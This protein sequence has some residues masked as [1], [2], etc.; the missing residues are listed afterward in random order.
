M[1]Q[2]NTGTS[3][4]TT[5]FALS[6]STIKFGSNIASAPD[7]IIYQL[8]AGIGTPSDDTVTSAKIVDGAIVNADI[9]ASAAIA[10]SKLATGA[11]PSGITVASANITDGTIVNADVNASAAIA[12]SKLATGLLPSG[13][14]INA[15]N[16]VDGTVVAAD[17]AANAITASELADDAVDTDAILNNAVTGAKIAMGSDAAGDI[18]YYNGTDY[19]R[20]P[21]GTA[22]QSLKVNSGASAPEW[23]TAAAGA[24]GGGT[25]N[26]FWENEATM[27]NSYTISTN[28]NA[29]VFGP[30]TVASGATITVPSG[31][32]LS[33]V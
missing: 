7:F 33:I 27:N 11:L 22:G 23:G 20:L 12:L 26:I 18:L 15:D 9:N 16:I 21:V 10:L 13:I 28:Y 4:P 8:G 14:T 5:G 2:P 30:L 31:S 6:G 25:E 24:K 3:T 17:I 32:V 29:G 1:Q 19:V